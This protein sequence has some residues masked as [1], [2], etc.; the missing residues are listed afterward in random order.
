MKLL[1][2]RYR[3]NQTDKNRYFTE[4]PH[5]MQIQKNEE[6]NDCF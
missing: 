2:P 6:D 4:P 3:D 5:Y 1:T